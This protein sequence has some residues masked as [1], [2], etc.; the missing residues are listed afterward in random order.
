MTT[1]LGPIDPRFAFQPG[2]ASAINPAG[3]VR[4]TETGPSDANRVRPAESDFASVLR[5]QVAG[6]QFS[7]HAQQRMRARAID[8]DGKQLSRLQGALGALGQKG[9]RTSLVMLDDVSLVVS[10]PNRTVI[11]AVKEPEQVVFTNIDSAIKV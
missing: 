10:V 4:R 9:G 3:A 2:R 5:E 7:Q 11:T 1:G 6:V 8:L